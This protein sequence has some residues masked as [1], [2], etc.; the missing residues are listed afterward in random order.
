MDLYYIPSSA[1]CRAV[2]MTAQALGVDLNKKF[3]NLR[4][5]EH[6]TPEFLKINPQHTVPTLIDGDFVLWESRVIMMYLCEK[7]DAAGK[8]YPKCPKLRAIVQHRMLFDLEILYRS[9]ADYFYPTMLRGERADPK[10]YTN[11]ERA[12]EMFNTL[13]EGKQFAAGDFVTIADISLLSTV[14]TFDSVKF[15][16]SKYP[17]V[18]RWYEACK[19]AVPGYA[20][21]LEGCKIFEKIFR[22]KL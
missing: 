2:L 5:S 10:M 12:F 8:W 4:K 6:L 18:A 16:L 13:L 9:F 11:I 15:D 21:N 20:E 14:T 1:P 7:F 22:N 3:L 17:N 19:I